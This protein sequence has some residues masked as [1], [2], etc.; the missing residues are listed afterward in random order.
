M[1]RAAATLHV[2]ISSL[3]GTPRRCA[4]VSAAAGPRLLIGADRLCHSLISSGGAVTSPAPPD[5][6]Y[7]VPRAIAGY[8]AWAL[9]NL[10]L[11]AAAPVLY[12]IGA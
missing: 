9:A 10:A 12:A 8:A 1:T 11:F 5:D 3:P 6:R 4:V 2:G 7:R